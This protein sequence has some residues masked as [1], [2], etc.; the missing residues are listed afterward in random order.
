[1]CSDGSPTVLH[2]G[3]TLAQVGTRQL[4]VV[5]QVEVMSTDKRER[6]KHPFQSKSYFSAQ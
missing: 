1:M 6:Y 2:S 4:L 3:E 5:M